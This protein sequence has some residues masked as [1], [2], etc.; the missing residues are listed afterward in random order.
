MRVVQFGF[1][2]DIDNIH[3]PHM[4]DTRS[5]CYIGT[6]DNMTLVNWLKYLGDNSRAVCDYFDSVRLE[7]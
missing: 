7:C 4:H 5:V 6:H 1:N 3:L 2:G